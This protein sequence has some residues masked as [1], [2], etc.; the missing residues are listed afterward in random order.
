MPLHLQSK[1]LGV[2]D[3]KIVKRIGGQSLRRVS[4]RIIAA[5]NVNMEEAVSKKR[6]RQDLYYRL[7]VLGIHLPPLRNRT[8]DITALCD[9]F[10]NNSAHHQSVDMLVSEIDK[11]KLYPWPGNVRELENVIERSLIF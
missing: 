11:L 2:L 1:L 4:V 7:G 8:T 3:D 10:I 9:H 6:F 5:T